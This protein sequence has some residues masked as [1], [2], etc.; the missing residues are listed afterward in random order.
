MD[1]IGFATFRYDKRGV[2]ASGGDYWATGFNDRLTDAIAAVKWLASQPT[3]DAS[4]VFV[5]GH[6]EGAL[7]AI[8][9]ASGAA[10]VAGAVLLAGSA[11]TGEQT[12]GKAGRLQMRSQAS[13]SGL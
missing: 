13:T 10:Q 3:L 6:S 7:I 5:L 1:E 12:S 2:G 11:K 4:R 8:R 9:L